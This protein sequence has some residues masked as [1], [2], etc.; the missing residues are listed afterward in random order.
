MTTLM[1]CVIIRAESGII[2]SWY[3]RNM[4]IDYYYAI[5]LGIVQGITEFIPVSSSGHLILL[6][7]LLGFATDNALYFDS[8][9][10]T[11]TLISLLLYFYKDL[12]NFLTKQPKVLVKMLVACVP[13]GLIGLLLDD[14]IDQYLRATWIV[15]VMLIVLSVIFLLVERFAKPRLNFQQIGWKEAVAM[16]LAQ[17]VALLFPGTSRS[18]VTLATGMTF[19]VQRADA[20][21]FSFVMVIP[22]YLAIAAKLVLDLKDAQVSSHELAT[23]AIGTLVAAVMGFAVIHFLLNYLRRSTLRP[24]AY[25]RIALA[26]VVSLVFF[27]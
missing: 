16:G 2:N 11:G 17:A 26:V 23:M 13:A 6:H 5:L 12:W 20:A 15:I 7:Q 19:G 4:S 22:L 3:S 10:N 25:Y 24:F 27:L 1:A 8:A 18:G 9:L 21:R 14:V